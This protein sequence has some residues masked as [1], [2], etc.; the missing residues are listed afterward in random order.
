VTRKVQVRR[1]RGVH[2]GILKDEILMNPEP[3]KSNHVSEWQQQ[4][5]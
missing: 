5:G 2:C 3:T 4:N 1:F